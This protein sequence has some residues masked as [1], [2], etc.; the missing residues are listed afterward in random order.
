MTA[1]MRWDMEE[2]VSTSS[3]R[4]EEGVDRSRPH[5]IHLEAHPVVNLIVGKCYVILEGVV[6]G[7]AI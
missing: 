7:H 4:V 3:G 6:P 1:F 5:L 2:N